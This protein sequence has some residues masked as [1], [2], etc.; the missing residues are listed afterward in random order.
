MELLVVFE[1]PGCTDESADSEGLAVGVGLLP[2]DLE[3]VGDRVASFDT[4]PEAEALVDREA[5]RVAVWVLRPVAAA[6]E[7]L[8]VVEV[9]VLEDDI[10]EERVPVCVRLPEEVGETVRVP[11]DDRDAETVAEED[12]VV[13]GDLE[14][15]GVADCVREDRD[16]TDPDTVTELVFDVVEVVVP[17]RVVVD[18][19]EA[20]EVDV[21]ERLLVDVLDALEV[22]LDVLDA[23]GVLE[24]NDEV[25][26]LLETV[27]DR[28]A[29][30]VGQ[31][32]WDGRAVSVEVRV[33]VAESVGMAPTWASC[34]ASGSQLGSGIIERG[35][36]STYLR[37]PEST[38]MPKADPPGSCGNDAIPN[39][40]KQKDA[41]R[42][43]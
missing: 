2:E 13:A 29:V 20:V 28:V 40:S 18:V 8:D 14:L 17:E 4:V 10:V 21:P 19:L 33:E 37:Y 35:C 36:T 15:E 27:A 34:L 16:E 1:G 26:E 3:V 6:E 9:L 12:R 31:D 25:V 42:I 41:R 32:V 43:L 22:L 11:A 23:V 5:E 39:N 24:V 30:R 7:V 38:A